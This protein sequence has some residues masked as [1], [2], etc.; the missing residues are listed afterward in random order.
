[1]AKKRSKNAPSG[2][3][4]RVI[5]AIGSFAVVLAAY[6]AYALVAVPLIEP[7]TEA[8]SDDLGHMTPTARIGNPAERFA[9]LFP[10]DS[11]VF[12]ETPKILESEQGKLLFQDYKNLG[13]GTDGRYRVQLIPLAIVF[14]PEA[15]GDTDAGSTVGTQNEGETVV[16]EAPGGA[17]LEF[18]E[19]FRLSRMQIGRLIGGRLVGPVTIRGDG[20]LPG[21]GDDLLIT[22]DNV[23]LSEKYITT[24]SVVDF[25]FGPH[26]GRGRGMTIKMSPGDES[27]RKD[28]R[29]PSIGGVESFELE[30]VERLCLELSEDE[31]VSEQGTLASARPGRNVLGKSPSKL[32]VEIT[33]RGPFRFDVVGKVA[34]FSDRVDVRLIHPNGPCDQ[35]N[36]EELA[37]FF[38]TRTE[39]TEPAN[40]PE[41][42]DESQT[43]DTFDLEPRR[44]VA[45]GNPVI[46]AA[47]SKQVYAR[48][49]LLEYD[50]Q[51]GAITLD[52]TR[53]VVLRQGLSEIHARKLDYRSNGPGRLGDV[54]AEGPGWVRAVIDDQR[55]DEPFEAGWNELLKVRRHE[56]SPVVSLYGSA[57]LSSPETGRLDAPEIHFYLHETP[58]ADDPEKFDV[59]PDRMLACQANQMLV[60]QELPAATEAGR[61]RSMNH[62][63]LLRTPQF[64]A[65]LRRL[66]LWFEEAATTS[67]GNTAANRRPSVYGPIDSMVPNS[68]VPNSRVPNSRVPNSRVPAKKNHFEVVGQLLRAK[69]L[70]HG[71]EDPELSEL[72]VEGGI[73]FVET[74]T[75][76]PDEKPMI[77]DGDRLHAVDVSRPHAAVTVTGRPA[78]FEARGLSLTGSNINLN[79]GTNRLWIDGPGRMN[80]PVDQDLEGKPL[81]NPGTLEIEWQQRMEFD[82]RKASFEES[83]TATGPLQRLQTE[84]LED[85]FRQAINFS[86]ETFEADQQPDIQLL[87]CRGGVRMDSRTFEGQKQTSQESLQVVDL[88]INLDS[89]ALTANGPGWVNSVRYGSADRLR[90]PGAERKD[91]AQGDGNDDEELKCLHVRFQGSIEGNVRLPHRRMT[92]LD[93][94]RTAYAPVDRFDAM[95][96]T[97]DPDVLGPEGVVMRC[98]RLSVH[99]MGA[100]DA[101]RGTVELEAHGNTVVEGVD[102]TARAIRMTY[103][104]AKDM[105]VLEGDGRTDAELFRQ[106]QVGGQTSQAAARKILYWPK[107]DQLRVEDARSFELSQFPA[108]R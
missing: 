41:S 73:R 34:T 35:L 90:L 4:P 6:G 5:R 96:T 9:S 93:Q 7:P 40:N 23:Q 63:I 31:L 19:P 27:H 15:D 74:Q 75:E 107:T 36:C 32:L 108:R 26:Y 76:K 12:S 106:E 79:R 44:I 105:L 56:G 82:G 65:A 28:R 30:H 86:A 80:V 66:E 62:N 25:R 89:G 84:T 1:M 37:I 100:T 55:A 83:V 71:K 87:L 13:E 103:S 46:V 68:M 24:S 10:A 8:R 88:T 20:K 95:L 57:N 38:V 104:Q 51:A 72:T 53:E 47:P 22:T 99:E 98:Q 58:R 48:G 60:S 33:C 77:L 18:D 54:I 102:F 43:A 49:Q 29:G 17:V 2:R 59:R 78:H 67:P 50:L 91:D 69:V 70:M 21:S 39:T 61:L 3:M 81:S 16:L 101:R 45:R 85:H 11:W 92:F 97:N 14:T 64:S 42:P 52:G 94:V